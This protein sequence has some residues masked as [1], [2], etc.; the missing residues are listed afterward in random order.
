VRITFDDLHVIYSWAYL[1]QLG[2]EHEKRWRAYLKGLVANGLSR[3]P[4]RQTRVSLVLL[5]CLPVRPI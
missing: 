1:Y 3:E 2:F 4:A 5:W